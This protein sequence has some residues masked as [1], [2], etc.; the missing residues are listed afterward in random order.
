MPDLPPHSTFR[1]CRPRPGRCRVFYRPPL[2]VS[3]Q[4][5]TCIFGVQGVLQT[6]VADSL[7]LL[8][9]HSLVRARGRYGKVV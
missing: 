3:R 6:T 4:P 2:Q 7:I 9:L 8:F 5:L 1:G